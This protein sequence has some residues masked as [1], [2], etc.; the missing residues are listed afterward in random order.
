M[1]TLDDVYTY[2]RGYD[3][4]SFEV[5]SCQ[6]QEPGEAD[7]GAFEAE[8]GF[9]LPDDFRSFTMSALGGLYMEVREELWPRAREFDVGPF[10]S[11][12]YGLKVFGISA[13]VPEW[14]D[15]RVQYR[16]LHDEGDGDLEIGELEV[17]LRRKRVQAR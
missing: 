15:L 3:T 5:F 17:R 13:D 12:L 1:A 16:R 2:F 8:A 9:R 4:R 6:G 7:L 11:F 10:W 14:L